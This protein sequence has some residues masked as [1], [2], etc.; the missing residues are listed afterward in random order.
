M[1]HPTT[2]ILIFSGTWFLVGAVFFI[3]GTALRRNQ[4]KKELNCT[5]RTWGKVIDI[6]QRSSRDSD[7]GYSTS[8]HPVF[9]YTI[10]TLRFVKESSYGSSQ[11]KY[12]IG[13]SVE[14]Y[15]DPADYHSYYI[16]GDALP[17]R[18]ATVFT[19]VGAAAIAVA[20]VSAV[21][22]PRFYA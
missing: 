18:L 7:G 2:F 5:M 10:G 20:I 15:Y 17:K 22:I 19:A 6:V 11:P 1:D 13:Q 14:V 8:L 3:I 21:L 16:P 12:A 9:E 4:K